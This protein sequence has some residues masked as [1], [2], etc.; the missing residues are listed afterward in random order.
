[1]HAPNNGGHR[2]R[3]FSAPRCI[4]AAQQPGRRQGIQL[5]Q[6]EERGRTVCCVRRLCSACLLA[7]A[8]IV[9][10]RQGGRKYV[11]RVWLF[12]LLLLLLLL[13]LACGSSHASPTATPAP[14]RSAVTLWPDTLRNLL[15]QCAIYPKYCVR[16]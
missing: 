13:C 14:A 4:T 12:A 7:L 3:L 16:P 5:H 6:L 2:L 8:R 1:M 15:T 10:S 11:L 9:S